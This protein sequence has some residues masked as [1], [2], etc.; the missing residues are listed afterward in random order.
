MINK[1]HCLSTVR[2]CI[3]RLVY[4][5]DL[6]LSKDLNHPVD[7]LRSRYNG[8]I[9]RLRVIESRLVCG[10]A[11][12]PEPKRVIIDTSKWDN[13]LEA[14]PITDICNAAEQME[15]DF[16]LHLTR[17]DRVRLFRSDD[18]SNIL[19]QANTTDP[20]GYAMNFVRGISGA[21]RVVCERGEQSFLL[22]RPAHW[23]PR[24][25]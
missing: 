17:R 15:G 8:V 21:E 5:R 13:G 4:D 20:L 25:E 24:S 6:Q 3:R 12:K 10:E 2:D 23:P 16:E 19:R 18:I 22:E 1:E 14:S 7:E 11:E 9:D